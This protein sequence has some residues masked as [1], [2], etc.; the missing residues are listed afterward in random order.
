[1][2]L[3]KKLQ[4]RD[5]ATSAR[6]G[7]CHQIYFQ[8]QFHAKLQSHLPKNNGRAKEKTPKII[9]KMNRTEHL[10]GV[11]ALHLPLILPDVQHFIL[12]VR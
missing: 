3:C 10:P 8:N 1:M 2:H 11:Q 4:Y 7:A 9:I 6:E 12:K 5:Q